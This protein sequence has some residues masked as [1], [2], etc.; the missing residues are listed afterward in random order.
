MWESYLE[1]GHVKLFLRDLKRCC[2]SEQTKWRIQF[3]N[4]QIRP[5]IR[6]HTGLNVTRPTFKFEPRL[7][8][9]T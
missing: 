1:T 6:V 5:I 9:T 3:K 2:S 8:T 4:V 7:G